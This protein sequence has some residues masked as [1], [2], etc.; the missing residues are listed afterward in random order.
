ME[1]DY[2]ERM[3]ESERKLNTFTVS[4]AQDI[5]SAAVSGFQMKKCRGIT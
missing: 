5:A 2:N 1:T 4:S 3:N